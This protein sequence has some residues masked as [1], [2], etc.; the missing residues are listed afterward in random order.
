MTYT[1]LALFVRFIAHVVNELHVFGRFCAFH[2]PKKRRGS[3]GVKTYSRPRL[4]ER[5][6]PRAGAK[7]GLMGG[8]K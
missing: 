5:E 6:G 4:H 8:T 2:C 1:F 7:R 3:V